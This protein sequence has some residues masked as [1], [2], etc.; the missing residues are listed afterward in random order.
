MTSF[1]SRCNSFYLMIQL[2]GKGEKLC[3]NPKV[4]VLW[5][6]NTLQNALCG[7][8]TILVPFLAQNKINSVFFEKTLNNGG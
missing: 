4:T 5:H 7:R 2:L 1:P 8:L 3:K 6:W